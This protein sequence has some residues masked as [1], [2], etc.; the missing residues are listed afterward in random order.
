VPST[1]LGR[2]V[3]TTAALA[4]VGT[5]PAIADQDVYRRAKVGSTLNSNPD[6]AGSVTGWGG[7]GGTLSYSTTQSRS[8]P[9][10]ARLAPSGAA[11]DSQVG[12]L[13]STLVDVSAG[14]AAGKQYTVS[15]WLRPDTANKPMKIQISYY[16]AANAFIS[17]QSTTMTSVVAGAWH[18]LEYTGD[19]S[20]V[21]NAAKIGVFIGL[22]STPAAGDAFYADDLTIRQ[23]NT[24]TGVRIAAAA[25]GA[26]STEDPGAASGI[27]YEYRVIARGTNNTTIAGPWTG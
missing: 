22:A 25:P 19:P 26:S 2:M 14:I 17:S 8:A 6:M 12:S 20:L 16:T 7:V 21:A 18:F 13:A 9:G 10:S 27:D 23:A 11:A 15:G 3:L 4:P 1:L 24:D 5:Q